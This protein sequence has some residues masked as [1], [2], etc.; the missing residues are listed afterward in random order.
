[1]GR[2]RSRS[3][4]S[5]R[6]D[7]SDSDRCSVEVHLPSGRGCSVDLPCGARVAELKACAQRL[8]SRRF[9]RLIFG[10]QQLEPE[11][12]LCQAKIRD[13]DVVHAVVQPVA[14]AATESA[15]ALYVHGGGVVTWGHLDSGGDSSQV[16]DQL[17]AVQQIQATDCAFAAIQDRKVVT[18]GNANFGA[19][20][21]QVRE[22]LTEVLQLRASVGA[23]AALKE[24]G[25]VV[26][27]GNPAY[28]GD[29]S[30]VQDQLRHVKQLHSTDPAF[31]AIKVD[32]TVV[33]WGNPAYGGDSSQVQ[34]QLTRVQEIRA[35]DRAF[36]AIKDDGKVVTWGDARKGGDSSHVQDQLTQVQ[37]IQAT[38]HAFA[39]VCGNGKVVTWG[40]LPGGGNSS[41]VR[42]QLTQ[43]QHIQATD[44]AFAA[45]LQD[46]KVL[47]GGLPA[48]A[49]QI[50][51]LTDVQHL[52]ATEGAFATIQ[53]DGTVVTWG[54]PDFGAGQ[55]LTSVRL[56]QAA[57]LGAFCAIRQHGE[58]VTWGKP[59]YGGD[60]C[61]AQ[62]PGTKF[63]LGRPAIPAE[64]FGFRGFGSSWDITRAN[65]RMLE[66]AMYIAVPKYSKVSETVDVGSSCGAE[67][68]VS[69]NRLGFISG[70]E[71]VLYDEPSRSTCRVLAESRLLFLKRSELQALVQEDCSFAN[72]LG[73][74][75]NRQFL[76]HSDALLQALQL[77][78]G[79]GWKGGHF[80]RHT[81]QF[82]LQMV[83]GKD[84]RDIQEALPQNLGKLS[85]PTVPRRRFKSPKRGE[86]PS[87][88]F[89][90]NTID[91]W[92]INWLEHREA[93]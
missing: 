80:D 45:I 23:F 30:R 66:Q 39:A 59:L 64:G 37:R 18:W 38:R 86:S 79:G 92:A 49:S 25:T 22:Q 29:S 72:S 65:R 14:V 28:G 24:D 1:M 57:R 70:L 93:V 17:S 63:L 69:L 42:T 82:C 32:G 88:N 47:T 55:S 54:Y 20:S 56:L 7:R 67:Q 46:G 3:D 68:E 40:H 5:D 77:N 60:S 51:E 19:D 16:R 62:G 84:G 73:R 89:R 11:L 33:T 27:W 34:E 78:E 2:S 91:T 10:G 4:P 71:S 87:R 36:A 44:F 50:Q 41:A 81:A 12:T 75:A 31:A 43:A 52:K 61:R 21:S 85:S 35:T 74:V 53:S 15:F 90:A 13:G 58:V 6:S 8:L 76:R 83:G 26:T 48:Y 9:L